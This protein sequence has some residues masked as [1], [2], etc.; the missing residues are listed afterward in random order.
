MSTLSAEFDGQNWHTLAGGLPGEVVALQVFNDGTGEALYAA[1]GYQ[2][3]IDWNF[4]WRMDKWNGQTW[5]AISAATIGFAYGMTVFDD[6]SGPALYVAAG[7]QTSGASVRKWNGTTWTTVTAASPSNS[8]I[9]ALEVFDDGS[10]DA[11]YISG[12][13]NQLGSI[14]ANNIARLSSTGA[15]SALGTGTDGQV[16]SLT[17]HDDGF[18]P[19]LYAGGM[20][21]TAGGTPASRI[22]KW[23]GVNWSPLASRNGPG[24]GHQL[25]VV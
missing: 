2:N 1:H 13:F 24:L 6:G 12:Q 9:V 14:P 16:L 15:L 5:T 10:G 21:D 25:G 8:S 17:A 22:A 23:D 4:Y 3:T 11:L 7:G 20:F 19:A 18:G